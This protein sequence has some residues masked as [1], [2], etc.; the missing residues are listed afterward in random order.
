MGSLGASEPLELQPEP[1]SG[2]DKNLFKAP[3]FNSSVALLRCSMENEGEA[4]GQLAQA[5]S[6]DQDFGG[7][8][9]PDQKNTP[10]DRWEFGGDGSAVC[11]ALLGQT[12]CPRP[13]PSPGLLAGIAVLAMGDPLP[14]WKRRSLRPGIEELWP[15]R[16]LQK[17]ETD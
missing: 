6:A 2:F 14:S 12:G 9:P 11:R 7:F 15:V 10:L 8:C 3:F 4:S 1:C 5:A 13:W 16:P 17:S